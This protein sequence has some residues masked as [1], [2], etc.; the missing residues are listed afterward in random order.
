M[1][2]SKKQRIV[3]GSKLALIAIALAFFFESWPLRIAL[4]AAFTLAS[5]EL[6]YPISLG[7]IFKPPKITPWVIL[8]TA[9]SAV[10]VILFPPSLYQ[11]ILCFIAAFSYDI[12]AYFIGSKYG[13][14]LFTKSPPFH[15]ISPSK[16]YEGYIGGLL[17]SLIITSLYVFLCFAFLK[18]QP[19]SST[20]IICI[21][22]GLVATIGDLLGSAAKRELA[23]KDSGD[24]LKFR[25]Y[26]SKLEDIMLGHGGYL[27]RLDSLSLVFL[28]FFILHLLV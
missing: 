6:Y 27:D 9:S 15:K 16:T 10:I 21:F 20:K 22:G 3:T 5:L 26:F 23:L 17:S 12:G 1:K 18:I 13:R 28:V 25:P 11:I 2:S 4:F 19:A 24:F 7:L 14:T 8:I